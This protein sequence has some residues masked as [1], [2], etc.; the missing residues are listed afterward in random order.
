MGRGW[1]HFIVGAVQLIKFRI[2]WSRKSQ[3]QK[4][5]EEK[6]CSNRDQLIMHSVLLVKLNY[7][8]FLWME[9]NFKWCANWL[10]N[11]VG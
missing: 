6:T 5:E 10:V 7:V 4:G 2:V 9:V 1:C 3:W 11:K 8:C